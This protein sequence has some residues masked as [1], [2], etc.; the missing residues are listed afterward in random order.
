MEGVCD[1]PHYGLRNA[2]GIMGGLEVLWEEVDH[3][4]SWSVL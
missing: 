4:Y 1:V 2:A 3:Y